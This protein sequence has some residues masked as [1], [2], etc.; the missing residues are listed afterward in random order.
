MQTDVDLACLAGRRCPDV[1]AVLGPDFTARWVSPS[2]EA[3]FGHDPA[4]LVGLGVAD[5]VHMEDLGPILNG[6]TEAERNGGRH[7]AVEC[8]LRT[9]SG[10]FLPTRATSTSFLHEGET[11][12]TLSIRTVADDD[13]V[14]G[15]R[16]RLQALASEAALTCSEM[17]SD[18][19]GSL[20]TILESLAAVI[21]AT[22]IAVWTGRR[23]NSQICT[24]WTQDERRAAPRPVVP[25]EAL[26]SSGYQVHQADSALPGAVAVEAVEVALPSGRH[27]PGVLVAE[28]SQTT[29]SGLWDDHNVDLVAVIG[30][31]VYA[32]SQRADSE[33][34]LL[35]RAETDQLTGL[36]NSAAVKERMAELLDRGGDGAVCAVFGDLDGFK[37][38]N[39]T[40]GHRMG[41]AVLM[42]VADGLRSAAGDGAFV[43]RIGGDEFVV[44]RQVAGTAEGV[45]LL[46][47]CRTTVREGLSRFGQVDISLGLA[48]SDAGDSAVDLL[49]RA[50]VDMYTE[51][52]R[53][54]SLGSDDG[55]PAWDPPSQVGKRPSGT[56]IPGSGGAG[57]AGNSGL[58]AS[59]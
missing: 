34:L 57:E 30:G 39:D 38:L 19:R 3:S 36:L 59:R 9:A 29:G 25:V 7:A 21:G 50:D 23:G 2:V 17:R 1:L 48:L 11:W 52:R 49:H 37:V 32:A 56:R 47:R 20:L 43:G 41:D 15:R 13:A 4:D 24:G 18:E 5:L 44:V 14:V 16:S 58:P 54:A 8:R 42:A 27:D 51:K 26:G 55:V 31:L 45:R 28:L 46:T 6:I 53:R 12:W 22:G 40:L 33:Q 35:Q 10:G